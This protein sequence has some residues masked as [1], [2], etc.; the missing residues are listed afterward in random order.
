MSAV[1]ATNM[2]KPTGKSSNDDGEGASTT[3]TTATLTT[4]TP[5][6]VRQ[7]FTDLT[8]TEMNDVMSSSR[9][10][11]DD[12]HHKLLWQ[13]MVQTATTPTTTIIGGGDGDGGTT[14][15]PEIGS[16]GRR[17]NGTCF[18][19]ECRQPLFFFSRSGLSLLSPLALFQSCACFNLKE[20]SFPKF[21][22]LTCLS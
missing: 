16:N 22:A 15:I 3:T 4:N 9:Y 14:P 8:V 6:P 5:S 2:T 7:W 12:D 21:G 19:W 17:T 1:D 13:A 11:N 10:G 18:F 20:D